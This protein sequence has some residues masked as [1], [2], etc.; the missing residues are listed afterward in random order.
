MF[1]S[2]IDNNIF[3]CNVFGFDKILG[4]QAQTIAEQVLAK[5]KKLLVEWPIYKPTYN[6]SV[7]NLTLSFPTIP[8][9]KIN[10]FQNVSDY[11]KSPNKPLLHLRT[12]DFANKNQVINFL[13]QSELSPKIADILVVYGDGIAIHGISPFETIPILKDLGF[14]VGCVFNPTPIIRSTAEELESFFKKLNTNPH[15]MISQCTYNFQEF[16]KFCKLVPHNIQIIA[17]AGL[18][19]NTTNFKKLGINYADE[20]GKKHT[21]P[22]KELIEK[23]LAEPKC[24]GIYIC[25]YS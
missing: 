11:Q 15:F 14:R 23:F 19:N 4:F 20:T 10:P 22:S 9:R 2:I 3:N 24:A 8:A 1:Y 13:T 17:C 21:T 25:D 18:W 16:F 7:N 6:L 12:R 5:N